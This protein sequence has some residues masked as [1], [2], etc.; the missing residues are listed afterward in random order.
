MATGKKYSRALENQDTPEVAPRLVVVGSST[1]EGRA[2]TQL[3]VRLGLIEELS[4]L[5]VGPFYLLCDI[6]LQDLIAKLKSMPADAPP[7]YVKGE[8][9]DPSTYDRVLLQ[10]Q[11]REVKV[12]P[13]AKVRKAMEAVAADDA[14]VAPSGASEP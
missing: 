8:A 5:C 4:S 10:E 1:L 2:S 6:A 13:S 11:G 7:R 14:A 12:R 9:L 3:R